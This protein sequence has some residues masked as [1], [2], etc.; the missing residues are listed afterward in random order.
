VSGLIK[1]VVLRP[2][3]ETAIGEPIDVRSM[4][5]GEETPD[6]V[7]RLTDVVMSRLIDLIEQLRGQEA[8]AEAGVERVAD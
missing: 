1:N 8:P 2:K 6:E 5:I 7:R 3:V 4:L